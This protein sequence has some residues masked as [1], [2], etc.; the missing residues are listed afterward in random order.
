VVSA[1]SPNANVLVEQ[2]IKEYHA[3]NFFNA[4]KNWQEALNQYKNNPSARLTFHGIWK[5]SL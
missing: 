5:T 3:G 1:Q 2:G 4:I